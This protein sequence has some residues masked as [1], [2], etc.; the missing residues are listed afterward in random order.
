M[1]FKSIIAIATLFAGGGQ[2]LAQTKESERLVLEK[3]VY[4]ALSPE[5]ADRLNID[6]EGLVRSLRLNKE[7]GLAV[8]KSEERDGID[9]SI[10]DNR[11]F[12]QPRIDFILKR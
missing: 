9:I 11:Q 6:Y 2:A 3:G 4:Y 10:Y 5:L 12:A 7:E 1:N 8:K